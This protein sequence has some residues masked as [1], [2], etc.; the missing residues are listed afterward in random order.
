MSSLKFQATITFTGATPSQA[1]FTVNNGYINP[2]S[3]QAIN[4]V[5]IDVY[6]SGTLLASKTT[7]SS[8]QFIPS[9]M[10]SATLKATSDVI[11][12]QN[13]GLTIAFT[14]TNPLPTNGYVVVTFPYYSTVSYESYIDTS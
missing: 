4:S 2:T 1:R 11:G 12:N 3:S 6:R 7:S 14:P 5:Q 9:A 13:S 8:I 10:T